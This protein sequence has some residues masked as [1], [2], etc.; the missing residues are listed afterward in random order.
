MY[1]KLRSQPPAPPDE[2]SRYIP[3][4]Q[5]K[6]AIVDNADHEWLSQWNW[7]ARRDKH[8]KWYAARTIFI[9]DRKSGRTMHREILCPLDSQLIDHADGNGLNN[10]RNNI[11]I[12]STCQNAQNAKTPTTN[13]SGCKGVSWVPN[14]NKWKVQ[15]TANRKHMY[16][17]IFSDKRVA[18]KVY[19]EA[20]K[21]LHGEF[22]K[23]S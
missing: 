12:A 14:L 6:F 19:E 21:R 23:V 11:R 16:L 8:G 3:L 5:G 1:K 9:G 13:T 2:S 18:A 17:G 7:F 22:A 15:I 20:A 4:T 10:R